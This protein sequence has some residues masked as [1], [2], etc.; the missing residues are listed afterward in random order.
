MKP[1]PWHEAA[2]ARLVADRERL[3]HAILVHGAAGIGKTQF[4]RALAAAVLC[5][6][7]RGGLAC[8]ACDSC[9][10]LEQGNHPD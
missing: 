2:L 6:S 10:W 9:R 5:E 1:F 3:P 8:G 7:P 4:I